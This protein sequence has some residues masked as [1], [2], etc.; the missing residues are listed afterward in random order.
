MSSS[1]LTKATKPKRKLERLL[2][3]IAFL[4]VYYY[5]FIYQDALGLAIPFLSLT[6]LLAIPVIGTV[7]IPLIKY[8]IIRPDPLQRSSRSNQ[9]IRF[10][11]AQFPSRYLLER[12]DRCKETKE[13]CP[14][15]LREEGGEYRNIWFKGFFN[16]RILEE[17][18]GLVESTFE[19]GYT[20]KLI[21]YIQGIARW[22]IIFSVLAL[23]IKQVFQFVSEG[24]V[25]FDATALQ[26][27][28]PIVA[29]LVILV[30]GYNNKPDLKNPTG[31]WHAWQEINQM[32]I[33]WMKNHEA[34]LNSVVCKRKGDDKE[35]IST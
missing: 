11:Q 28:S 9:S 12:C 21:F 2:V 35:F 5:A 6:S 33:A 24:R 30:L 20:C 3:L 16:K 25:V 8:T 34:E 13:T 1:L 10:F 19:K 15:F 22:F 27:I 23:I 14:A 4:S 32:N 26:L 18:P 7:V 29:L 17:D 31:C